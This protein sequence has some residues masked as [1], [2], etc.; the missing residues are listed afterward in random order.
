MKSGRKVC[1]GGEREGRDKGMRED[2][3]KEGKDWIEGKEGLFYK[4]LK[5]GKDCCG[6]RQG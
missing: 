5:K 6:W 3:K 2:G 4:F 1:E